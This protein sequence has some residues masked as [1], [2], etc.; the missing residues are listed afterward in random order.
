MPN[1]LSYYPNEK[2]IHKNWAPEEYGRSDLEA[3]ARAEK[4][5]RSKG[6]LSPELAAQFMPLALIENTPSHGVVDG[7]FG[8]PQNARRNAMLKAMGLGYK[9]GNTPDE[10][11]RM[12]AAVLAEKAAL[13]GNDKAV[14]RYNGKGRAVEEYYG[15][16]AQADAPN[17]VRKVQE[18]QKMLN[19][20]KNTLLRQAYEQMLKGQP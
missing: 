12:A 1:A 16:V 17:H 14:E 19:H 20:P 8:Y 15:E 9:S 10:R 7:A 18:M 13:Y 5:A 3:I 4:L 11:A 6:I 2:Y